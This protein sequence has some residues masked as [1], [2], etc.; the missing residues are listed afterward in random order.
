MIHFLLTTFIF[1]STI[2]SSI[3]LNQNDA[4]NPRKLLQK[5][6]LLDDRALSQIC[7]CCLNP[8]CCEYQSGYNDGLNNN[9]PNEC[10]RACAEGYPNPYGYGYAEGQ[11][12]RRHQSHLNAPIQI[13]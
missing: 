12:E 11:A 5:T 6:K 9:I 2:S 7:Q 3:S 4:Q 10:C 8:D 1:F 13:D